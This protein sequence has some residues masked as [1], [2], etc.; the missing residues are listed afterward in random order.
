MS[1]EEKVVLL[2]EGLEEIRCCTMAQFQ[3][4]RSKHEPFDKTKH[5]NC[6]YCGRSST[7]EH[8]LRCWA[9]IQSIA[10]DL[11]RRTDPEAVPEL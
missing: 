10:A 2:R 6:P 11:L 5:M 3:L 4:Q 9:K 7:A 8:L 1:A